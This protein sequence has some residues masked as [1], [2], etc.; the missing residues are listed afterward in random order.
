MD[1][2]R[3]KPGDDEAVIIHLC[4][5]LHQAA[6]REFAVLFPN[7]EQYGP[8]ETIP[9]KKLLLYKASVRAVY[10]EIIKLSK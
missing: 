5:V 4:W 9:P 3:Y 2:A 8:I 1:I 10:H 6:G 7:E